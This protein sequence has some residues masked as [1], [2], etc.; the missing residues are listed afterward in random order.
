MSR[1][2]INSNKE[3]SR[4]SRWVI[5]LIVIIVLTSVVVSTGVLLKTLVFDRHKVSFL[6]A[7]GNFIAQYRVKDGYYVKCDKNMRGIKNKV[8]KGWSE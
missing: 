7:D 6:D 3:P 1:F 2:K 8:F 5:V 4:S